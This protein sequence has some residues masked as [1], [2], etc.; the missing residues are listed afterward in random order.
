MYISA[1]IIPG[2]SAPMNSLPTEASDVPSRSA[3][4]TSMMLGG[5]RMPSV[6][7]EQAVPTAKLLFYLA[8]SIGPIESMPS[9]AT[10]APTIPV[11]AA[12][13]MPTSTTVTA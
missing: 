1:S 10:E 3:I 13:R 9:R 11:E 5:I 6:P 2:I 7:T 8:C 4:K 12:S